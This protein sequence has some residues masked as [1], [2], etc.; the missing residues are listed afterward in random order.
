MHKSGFYYSS[1]GLGKRWQAPGL[2]KT[3]EGKIFAFF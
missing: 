3:T 2:R 1:V